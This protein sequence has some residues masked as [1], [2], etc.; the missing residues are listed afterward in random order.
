MM[1]ALLAVLMVGVRVKM[2]AEKKVDG[3]VVETVE[4]K[5]LSM[6]VSTVV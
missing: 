3:L 1:V 2:T 4:R 6:V 5:V